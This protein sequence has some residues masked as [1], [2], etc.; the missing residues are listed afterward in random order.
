MAIL[1]VLKRMCTERKEWTVVSRGSIKK[2]LMVTVAYVFT[3]IPL[4]FEQPQPYLFKKMA[5][6]CS[7]KKQL[8]WY[9]NMEELKHKAGLKVAET[10]IKFEIASH[11]N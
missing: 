11:F 1:N 3:D 6:S 10:I 2:F 8:K 5:H 4:I 7:R 9:L